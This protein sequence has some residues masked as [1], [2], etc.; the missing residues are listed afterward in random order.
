M[1]PPASS[2]SNP[3]ILILALHGLPTP[4][5]DPFKPYEETEQQLG[6]IRQ[7]LALGDNSRWVD[8]PWAFGTVNDAVVQKQLYRETLGQIS[9]YGTFGSTRVRKFHEWFHSEIDGL[10]SSSCLLTIIAYSAGASIVFAWLVDDATTEE[11]I[12]RVDKIFCVAGLYRFQGP[13]LAPGRILLPGRDKAVAVRE[14]PLDAKAICKRVVA[15]QLV[16]MLGE[17]DTT[18][19]PEHNNFELPEC[20]HIEYHVIDDVDHLTILTDKRDTPL[21]KG[22]PVRIAESIREMMEVGKS[23]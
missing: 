7:R 18:A 5:S 12:A 17:K 13:G 2:N 8:W 9:Y 11:D 20:A 19:S 16:V 15:E 6:L 10:D 1:T 4:T 14:P 21:H 23:P 22:A 3:D